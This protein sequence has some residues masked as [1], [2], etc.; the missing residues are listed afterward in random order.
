MLRRWL[1]PLY[2]LYALP[3]V[4]F[5]AI[6]VP[7]FLNADETNHMM[8]AEM[9]LGGDVIGRRSDQGQSG[10]KIDGHILDV[11]RIYWPMLSTPDLR[12]TRTITEPGGQ[13]Q[14]GGDRI[15]T[16]I[17]NTAI[18]PPTLYAPLIAGLGL[19]K[20]LDLSI[21]DSFIL[22]RMVSALVSVGLAA[23]AIQIAARGRLMLF[24]TMLLP[25]SI[26]QMAAFSQDG[27]L[28]AG[29]ALL[30]ALLTRPLA[31]ERPATN[32]EFVGIAA[33]IVLLSWSRPTNLAFILLLLPL[34]PRLTGRISVATVFP[35][36]MVLVL[37]WIVWMAAA[38]AVQQVWGNVVPSVP[39][40]IRHLMANPL[41]FFRALD[42]TLFTG[43]GY[44]GTVVMM[45]GWVGWGQ[46]NI[47][48]E[49]WFYVAILWMLVAAVL[50][51]LLAAGRHS[52]RF[53]LLAAAT[54]LISAVGIYF[55]QYLS[56]SAVG[57]MEVSGVQGRYFVPLLASI[58]LALPAAAQ[59]LPQPWT[60]RV[61]TL[62]TLPVLVFPLLTMIIMPHT[63]IAR[64]YMQ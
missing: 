3:L 41:D 15:F 35:A 11:L 26:T 45:L 37:G 60:R 53:A 64:A 39:G 13:V 5:M 36:S 10:G 19:G 14:W 6:N 52:S 40:Q 57:G 12:L 29:G 51:D 50:S 34:A 59:W 4:L 9:V 49:H 44:W 56:F 43:S 47:T 2:L 61:R 17:P 62:L 1:A 20:V 22:A 8:R 21:A 48:F 28:I 25:M 58:G 55:L 30:V 32:A 54:I 38:V 63:I 46:F 7:V 18:Y 24:A 33:L 23:L 42:Q 16:H 31:E 27:L